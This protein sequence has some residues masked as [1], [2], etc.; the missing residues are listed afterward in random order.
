MT[1]ATAWDALLN[2]LSNVVGLRNRNSGNSESLTSCTP[3]FQQHSV[4]R[5]RSASFCLAFDACF[6]KAGL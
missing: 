1:A 4:L 5:T 6:D 2:F 3:G